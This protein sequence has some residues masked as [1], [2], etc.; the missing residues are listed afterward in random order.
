MS[1]PQP[2]PQAA[3]ERALAH[4]R[5]GRSLHAGLT[6]VVLVV[7]IALLLANTRSVKV[8]WVVGST[9]QPLVWIVLVTTILGWVLGIFTALLF[10]RRRA[11]KP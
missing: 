8:S 11:Q 5:S 3:G 2:P 10:R 6:I 1:E 9:H 7:I 4:E